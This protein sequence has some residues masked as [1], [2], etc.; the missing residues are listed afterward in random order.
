M[1]GVISQPVFGEEMTFETYL[2]YHELFADIPASSSDAL[3]KQVRTTRR[4][5]SYD[6]GERMLV[7]PECLMSGQPPL[8]SF[9]QAVENILP[10]ITHIDHVYETEKAVFN[11]QTAILTLDPQAIK[12]ARLLEQPQDGLLRTLASQGVLIRVP[13]RVLALHQVDQR[14]VFA[15]VRDTSSYGVCRK[16]NYDIAL[17]QL[18]GILLAP[19]EKLNMNKK[20][21]YQPG[22]CGGDAYMFNEGVCGGSTQLFWNALVNPYLYVTKRYNHNERYAGF[23]GSNVLGDDASMYEMSKQ[24]EI[25]NVADV[26]IY[27]VAF[28]LADG[29][30]ALLS[31]VPKTDPLLVTIEKKQ[32]SPLTS[33]VSKSVMDLRTNTITYQQQRDS[34]YYGI[35]EEVDTPYGAVDTP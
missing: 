8:L 28:P 20:I 24:F 4:C 13:K 33:V 19:E 31:F 17:R 12:D 35:N 11:Y 30:T 3:T 10:I 26:P 23:Y 1:M 18:D 34:R 29:N 15:A 9:P 2:E 16:N 21:A 25:Q 32:T 5:I 22:Y 7:S 14:S 6:R 27:F